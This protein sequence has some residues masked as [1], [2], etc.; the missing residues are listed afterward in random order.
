MPASLR[1]APDTA[2]ASNRDV[3]SYGRALGKG[4]VHLASLLNWWM[5]QSSWSHAQMGA[6]AD[7]ATGERKWLSS[8]QLSHIRNANVKQVG[9]QNLLGMGAVNQAVHCWH[10]QGERDAIRRYGM[11]SRHGI[12]EELLAGSAW[13]RHPQREKE[14]LQFH[15]F[16]DVFVGL[17]EIPYVSEVVISPHETRTLTDEIAQLLDDLT[18]QTGLG[19]RGGMAEILRHY[20]IKDTDR[21]ERLQSVILGQYVYSQSECEEELFALSQLVSDLRGLP[22]GTYGPREFYAEVSNGR[23]RH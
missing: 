12:T 1:I 20:P 14:P 15:D 3:P 21:I 6:V 18:A 13:L 16:C 2:G 23:R 5:G 4:R 17:L 8:P 10:E 22:R 19:L 11:F 9:F 7:W